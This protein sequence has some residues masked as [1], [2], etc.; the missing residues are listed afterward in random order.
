MASV[1]KVY[2]DVD[3]FSYAAGLPKDE[4]WKTSVMRR[5]I[6]LAKEGRVQIVLSVAAIEVSVTES[7]IP[8]GRAEPYLAAFRKYLETI[9]YRT[10]EVDVERAI[11]LARTYFAKR[12]ITKYE[13]AIHI[14]MA[15]LAEADY[16]LTWNEGH[17]L[18][19]KVVEKLSKLNQR[20]GIKTPRIV[21]PEDFRL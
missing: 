3:A 17:L 5:V 1:L 20:L 12:V 10:V 15:C 8:A 4:E 14:A 13:N 6:N 2:L 19:G 18:K 7:G 9:S 21:R 16:F 11:S